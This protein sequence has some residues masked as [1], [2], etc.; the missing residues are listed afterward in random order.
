[1]LIKLSNLCHR[2]RG[3]N[4][5]AIIRV[6]NYGTVNVAAD[7]Y[8]TIDGGATVVVGPTAYAGAPLAPNDTAVI[9]MPT[10]VIPNGNYDFFVH[11]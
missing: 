3:Q 2:W 6:R 4:S 1:V 5:N 8:Y 11:G 7:C 10:F 9:T